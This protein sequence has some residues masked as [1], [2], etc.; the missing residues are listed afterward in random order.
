MGTWSWALY[1]APVW[2]RNI[3]LFRRIQPWYRLWAVRDEE[4]VGFIGMKG[5]GI[6][7]L[8]IGEEDTI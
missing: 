5:P 2:A 7:E 6:E 1:I 4:W 8:Y 3:C